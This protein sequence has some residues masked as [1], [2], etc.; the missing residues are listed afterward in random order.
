MRQARKQ[1]GKFD[2]CACAFFFKVLEFI[3]YIEINTVKISV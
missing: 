2:L 3:D 1:K